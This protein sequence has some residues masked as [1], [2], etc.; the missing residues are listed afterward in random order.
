MSKSMLI[1]GGGIGGVAVANALSKK[2]GKDHNIIVVDRKKDFEYRPSY[3]WVMMGWRRP[4]QIKRSLNG[5]IGKGI[6]YVQGSASKID[7]GNRTVIIDGKERRYDYLIVSL[8]A[9]L[10]PEAIPGLP[11]NEYHIYSLGA[12]E[13]LRDA[14]ATFSEGTLAIGVAST[15]FSCP[16]A[17][18]EAALLIDCH[19]REARI[20]DKVNIKFFTP[21]PQPLPVA[22]PLVGGK[23]RGM[24]S[25][26]GIE[27]NSN[28]KLMFVDNKNKELTFEKGEKIKF[29]LLFTVP[30]HKTPNVVKESGLTDASGWMPV[31]RKNLRTKY[32]DLYAI[33]DVIALKLPSGMMLPKAGVFAEHQA[34]IVAHNIAS[35]I[36]GHNGVKDW[37]GKGSCLL[38]TGY[39]KA[40]YMRGEF[41]AEPK[42]KVN[43][44]RPSRIWHWGKV[45]FEKYWLWK[46]F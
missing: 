3:L 32:D 15:P 9:D 43:L 7:P 33:G 24:L 41:F 45:L 44:R 28:Q 16:A 20:R 22:G 18:Y 10:A 6:R 4:A 21:E 19:L 42:P 38:E 27:Y 12:T 29:D 40:V 5:L 39:G 34:R 30:P 13:R 14:L 1:L 36:L 46:H 35:E 17:P 2:L 26:Q 31:D 25:K 23:I 8:G 11:E 37:D